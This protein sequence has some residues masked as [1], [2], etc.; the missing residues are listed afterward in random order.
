MPQDTVLETASVTAITD[1]LHSP[2]DTI[3]VT[4]SGNPLPSTA[5]GA[6]GRDAGAG[7]RCCS[8]LSIRR[9]NHVG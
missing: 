9:E 7:G 1:A 2:E 4:S 5:V 8:Y 6:A 3:G